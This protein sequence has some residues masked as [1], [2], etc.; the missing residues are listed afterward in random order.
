MTLRGQDLFL[1]GQDDVLYGQY[2]CMWPDWVLCDQDDKY[3]A[4]ITFYMANI[5]FM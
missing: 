4:Q 1:C 2:I 3:V 5:F